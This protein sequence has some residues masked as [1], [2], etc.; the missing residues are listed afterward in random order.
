MQIKAIL[1]D[2]EEHLIDY[3]ESLL[4]EVWPQLAICGR[5][6]NGHE[7]LELIEGRR[8]HLAFLDV[9]MPG[10][11]GMEVARRVAKSC[12]IVFTTAYDHYAVNAFESGALDYLIKPVSRERLEKAVE[13]AK[14]QLAVSLNPPWYFSEIVERLMGKMEQK[15]QD[16]LQ[17]IRVQ[18]GGGVKL[19]SVEEVC[20]FRAEDK[21][22]VVVTGGEESLISKSIRELSEE[23]DPS[24]FWRI[25]RG[26]IVNV[27]Q[28]D[29]VNRSVTGRGSIRLKERR[30]LLVVSR[31]YLHLFKQM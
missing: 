21:Y 24:K 8:P 11:C 7:A 26:A 14:K 27:S 28:I 30:E 19:I 29:K 15:H 25:H 20:Y 23:L 12:W 13:R 6:K 10:V 3:L 4:G 18:H 17:W 9:R 1:A 16:F 22:T 2:D 5:A 31:P